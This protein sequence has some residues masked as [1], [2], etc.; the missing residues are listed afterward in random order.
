MRGRIEGC[1][2]AYIVWV[3]ICDIHSSGLLTSLDYWA[4]TCS[5]IASNNDSDQG[6][7]ADA[8]H[9]PEMGN[10]AHE[11]ILGGAVVPYCLGLAG[12]VTI[13]YRP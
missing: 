2:L 13:G 10:A 1:A 7:G 3:S 6:Q 9:H 11:L 12:Q 4:K 5:A 8:M